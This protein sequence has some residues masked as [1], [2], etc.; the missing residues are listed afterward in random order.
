MQ[1]HGG[2]IGDEKARLF[3]P[4]V[5]EH[6]VQPHENKHHRPADHGEPEY[7]HNKRLLEHSA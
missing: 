7:L 2:R 4:E 5:G 1:R 6:L 3:S